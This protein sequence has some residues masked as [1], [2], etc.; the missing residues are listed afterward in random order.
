MVR[1][2]KELVWVAAGQVFSLGIGFLSIKILTNT[3][4]AAAYG[5]L[6][7]GVSIAAFISLFIYGPLG[8]AA[9]RFYAICRKRGEI[10]HYI[11]AFRS[12]HAR[13]LWM[14][15]LPAFSI[16]LVLHLVIDGEWLYV[17]AAAILYSA[18]TGINHGFLSMFSGMRRRAVV[19]LHQ[20][21]ESA[22]RLFGAV[23][24]MLI[25]GISPV[26]A[27]FGYVAGSLLMLGSLSRVAST[28]SELEYEGAQC[29]ASGDITYNKVPSR[30]YIEIWQYVLPFL[31]WAAIGFAFMHGDR[32]VLQSV[33]GPEAVG[34]YVAIYQI[35]SALPNAIIS[36]ISQYLEPVIF[37][38]FETSD[39]I[40]NKMNGA[41]L[42]QSAVALIGLLLIIIIF[43]ASVWSK[44]IVSFVAST[45][46]AQHSSLLAWIVAGTGIIGLGQVLTIQGL[47]MRRP[48]AYIS[49]KAVA[50]TVLLGAA[51]FGATQRG[52]EGV[53]MALVAAGCVYLASILLVNARL[54]REGSR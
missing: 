8:Q 9:T 42:I 30:M 51:Y 53:A 27:L 40:E 38:R 2:R 14:L 23:I 32:W 35:G 48:S 6:M 37:E 20:T 46:F 16:L 52:A 11:F 45:E 3:M 49:A 10:S 25:A 29:T 22:A 12:I 5:K 33:R 7:L 44:E 1:E 47:A 18:V 21:G 19:A 4:G 41:S 31:A 43:A 24:A 17:I 13:L 26:V 28:A 50:A 15:I 54:A 39:A 36:I 34:T